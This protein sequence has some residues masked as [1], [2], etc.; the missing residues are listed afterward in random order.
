MVGR[1]RKSFVGRSAGSRAGGRIPGSVAMAMLAVLKGA[2]IVRVHDV[3]PTM[4]ALK[5]V[6]AVQGLGE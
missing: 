6:M 1:P 2:R 4:D 3:G 5:T